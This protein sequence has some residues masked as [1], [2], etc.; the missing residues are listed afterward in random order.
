V[1]A[2]YFAFT[3]TKNLIETNWQ[4]KSEGAKFITDLTAAEVGNLSSTL[5]MYT[6]KPV[7]AAGMST[8]RGAYTAA[9]AFASAG[10]S[11]AGTCP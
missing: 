4:D 2:G 1:V 5:V 6:G 10:R 3:G 8:L 11:A 9:K 7:V